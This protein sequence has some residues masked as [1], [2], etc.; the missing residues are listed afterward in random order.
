MV[1]GSSSTRRPQAFISTLAQSL[2]TICGA[3]FSDRTCTISASLTPG[4]AAP[5]IRMGTVSGSERATQP[6]PSPAIT[7]LEI[8]EA[9]CLALSLQEQSSQIIF[10][11]RT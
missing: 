8:T 2:E 9:D 5:I 11:D 7:C 10:I 3:C 4:L 6:T 1:P